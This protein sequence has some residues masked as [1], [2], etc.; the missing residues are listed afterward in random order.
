MWV[1]TVNFC[2]LF[3]IFEK[4]CNKMLEKKSTRAHAILD[5]RG[6]REVMGGATVQS[7]HFGGYE[8]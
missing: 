1:F 3:C 4:F 7:T 2:Q 6:A 5:F 8:T